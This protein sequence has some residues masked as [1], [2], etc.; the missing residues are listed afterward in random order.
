MYLTKEQI[1]VRLYELLDD[2]IFP[3]GTS[4]DERLA[5]EE[6]LQ[7]VTSI[8][9]NLP[10]TM[11]DI[12]TKYHKD[13]KL[14]YSLPVEKVYFHLLEE[15]I[16]L[17][18][19]LGLK[20]CTIHD[21]FIARLIEVFKQNTLNNKEEQLHELSDISLIVGSIAD[22]L[23]LGE[24]LYDGILEV[25][26]SNDTKICSIE[27]VKETIQELG[28]SNNKNV[29]TKPLG[30]GKYL[31]TDEKLGKSI[32]PVSYRKPDFKHLLNN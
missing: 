26:R 4:L 15:V 20:D 17:G 3:N 30:S 14:K 6:K 25:M 11:P 7:L 18:K 12:V 13:R 19:S 1:E 9:R 21:N 31:I 10:D 27:Q 8:T 29:V 24:L 16:E 2:I 28:L 32:K 22:Y 5:V 23:E